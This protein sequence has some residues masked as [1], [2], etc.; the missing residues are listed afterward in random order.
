MY[1]ILLY[2]MPILLLA[3]HTAKLEG[4]NL[5]CTA[6]AVQLFAEVQEFSKNTVSGV[7]YVGG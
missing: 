7:E 5:D 4:L 1:F 2:Y 3:K 6:S